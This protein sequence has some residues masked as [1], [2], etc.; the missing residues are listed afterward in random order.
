MYRYK[1]PQAVHVVTSGCEG[2][3]PIQKV[4]WRYAT[5]ESGGQCVMTCGALQMLMWSVV[6][7]GS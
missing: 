2:A 1:L 3:E 7:L 5:M 4:V 6:N